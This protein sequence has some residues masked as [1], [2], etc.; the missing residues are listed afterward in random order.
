MK[1]CEITGS[2]SLSFL[3][4]KPCFKTVMMIFVIQE[5][6]FTLLPKLGLFEEK[7]S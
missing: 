2:V 6:V 3:P 4:I 5:L 7:I 1:P